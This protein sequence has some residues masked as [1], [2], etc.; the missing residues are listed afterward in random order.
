METS[1]QAKA[2]SITE[3]KVYHWILYDQDRAHEFIRNK[4]TQQTTT[5]SHLQHWRRL[6]SSRNTIKY[7]IAWLVFNFEIERDKVKIYG[8]VWQYVAFFLVA[9]SSETTQWSLVTN[10]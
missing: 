9:I 4:N 10:N 2:A 5:K 6:F 8:S 3:E 7:C 1:M